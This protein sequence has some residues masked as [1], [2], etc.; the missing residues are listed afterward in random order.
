[1]SDSCIRM[2]KGQVV[3][4]IVMPSK[5]HTFST[6]ASQSKRTEVPQN[7]VIISTSS[8]EFVA[9]LDKDGC[10]CLRIGDDLFGICLN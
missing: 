3:L 7:K 8:L 10:E 6:A 5:S 4:S 2:Q 1:M 9:I